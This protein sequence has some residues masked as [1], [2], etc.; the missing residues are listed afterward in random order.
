M[1]Q[2]PSWHL[3]G[4]SRSCGGHSMVRM[5]SAYASAHASTGSASAG[6]PRTCFVTSVAA[7]GDRNC[8]HIC[9]GEA[10]ATGAQL[11]PIHQCLPPQTAAGFHNFAVSF[12][13][14]SILTGL[15]GAPPARE[16]LPVLRQLPATHKLPGRGS[17][18]ALMQLA[19]IE[20]A[21]RRGWLPAM[22][23]LGGALPAPAW[24]Q[25]RKAPLSQPSTA[26]AG[27]SGK[28]KAQMSLFQNSAPPAALPLLG[29]VCTVPRDLH[30]ADP[31]LSS[32][33]GSSS[34]SSHSWWH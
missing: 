25:G 2:R 18:P 13:V 32:G 7:T 33:D 15:T 1:L 4:T 11:F 9:D 29:Q 27:A 31:W 19:S 20:A 34:R 26:A 6:S 3:W 30:M 23:Q 24:L 14:V 22:A 16:S 5:R 21:G 8:Q 17:L 28:S 10:A 12:T